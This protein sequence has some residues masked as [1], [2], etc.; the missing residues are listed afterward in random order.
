MIFQLIVKLSKLDSS[1]VIGTV[2]E[3]WILH[4]QESKLGTQIVYI[5]QCEKTKSLLSQYSVEIT[6]ILQYPPLQKFFVK[7]ICSIILY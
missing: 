1:V 2:M 7:L 5:T 3:E 6:E 4:Y